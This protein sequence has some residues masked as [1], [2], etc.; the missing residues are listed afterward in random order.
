MARRGPIDF[1][2]RMTVIPI[3]FLTGK[4]GQ[5]R[6]EGNSA[7]WLCKCGDQIPLSGRCYF[8]FGDD[9][10]TVCPTCK[11]KYRVIGRRPTPNAGNKSFAVKEFR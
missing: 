11:R 6:A 10:H 8:Q 4:K 7:S 5:A 2:L 3:I 1:E 9:C